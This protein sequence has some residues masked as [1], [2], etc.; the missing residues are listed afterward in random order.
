MYII[1][2][3]FFVS[4]M[5]GQIF[6]QKRENSMTTINKFNTQPLNHF[7]FQITILNLISFYLLFDK[8]RM[9]RRHQVVKPPAYRRRQD[10]GSDGSGV[11]RIT[12]HDAEFYTIEDVYAGK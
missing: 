5:N 3:Y 10:L 8:G 7:L 12:P 11:R 9:L 4:Y 6:T 2:F 1:L